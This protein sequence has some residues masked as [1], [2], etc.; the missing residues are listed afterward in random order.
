MISKATNST[1]LQPIDDRFE[2]DRGQTVEGL[3]HSLQ[4]WEAI[5]KTDGET[6]QLCLFKK[7]GSQLDSD[8]RRLLH[9]LVR[10]IRGVLVDRTARDVLVELLDVVED[11]SEIGLRFFGPGMPLNQVPKSVRERSFSRVRTTSGRVVVWRQISR[12]AQAVGSLHSADIVHGNICEAAVFVDGGDSP[13]LQLGGYEGAVHIGSIDDTST[14]LLEP[15]SIVSI[16]KDWHDLAVLAEGLL[17]VEHNKGNTL[18]PN[19]QKLLNRLKN[20]PKFSHIE[21][22]NLASEIGDLCNELQRAGSSGRSELVLFPSKDVIRKDLRVLVPKGVPVPSPNELIEQMADDLKSSPPLMWRPPNSRTILLFTNRATYELK[23]ES[24]DDR[25]ARVVACRPRRANDPTLNAEELVS[26]F[27]LCKNPA[28]AKDRIRRSGGGAQSWSA[29]N[30]EATEAVQEEKLPQW[31]ALNLIEIF[32]LMASRLR[33]YP[34]EILE[35]P[36]GGSVRMAARLDTNRDEWRAKLGR[37][38]AADS[39]NR[40]LAHDDGNTDWTLATTDA[41]SIGAASPS[42]SLAEIADRNG[43]RVFTFDVE[44][45]LP[46]QRNV[47]LRPRPDQGQESV[48]RRRLRSISA[49][50]SDHDLL[51]AL[52]DPNNVTLD[53]ALSSVASPGEPHPDLDSSKI[54]AWNSIQEGNSIDLVVGPPGVGK[55]FLVSRLV[56]SVLQ[57][58]PYSRILISAQNHD[59]LVEMQR[60]LLSHLD[61]EPHLLVRVE[62]PLDGEERTELRRDSISVLTDLL[63]RDTNPLLSEYRRDVEQAVKPRYNPSNSNID[64]LLRDTDHLLLRSADITLATANS[65]IVEELRDDGERF[66]WVIVE[67]AARASGPELLGVLSL[68]NRRLLI[69]DHHQLAP[70]EAERKASFYEAEVAKTLLED[71]VEAIE[72][73]SD[74]PA[75]LPESLKEL[76]DDD[77]LFGDVVAAAARL[78]QPFREIS[79]REEERSFDLMGGHVSILTEQSRMHPVICKIVSDSFY[80][81]RLESSA[82]AINRSPAV[83]TNKEFLSAPLVILDLPSLSVTRRRTFEEKVGT[84]RQNQIEATTLIKVLKELS[85]SQGEVSRTLAVLTPFTAQKSLLERELVQLVDPETGKISGFTSP[86]G[87]GEFVHT[88]DGFQGGEADLVVVS[89]V[90][91]NEWV[92]PRALGFLSDRRRMNVLLS[93]ARDKL[94][95]I[96]S[97]RFL[98]NAV[99]AHDPDGEGGGRLDFLQSILRSIEEFSENG[100]CSIVS[101]DEG[102]MFD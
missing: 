52:D 94:V 10:R 46:I 91:N 73:V 76:A 90:R 89:L 23:P 40:E 56:G 88:V 1:E 85:P 87:N 4:R 11:D 69:G 84:S 47:I 41:L 59:A 21:S 78:E 18:L 72:T 20:P 95:L 79:E 19:E 31:Y 15:G 12:L 57:N 43:R 5:S 71:A 37:P 48:I 61:S 83:A 101:C 38:S 17:G 9:E 93:R 51:L 60:G 96:T 26:E 50:R 7:T 80:G 30:A 34:V 97:L 44:G 67:E 29:L 100:T 62:K 68:G 14:Q 36:A 55:S 64:A 8:L 32:S 99:R 45:K 35:T 70:F 16:R 102:G 92:G 6:Y 13:V 63:Q 28:D 86:K 75:E 2:L 3:A 65:Y 49:V 74:L 81:G 33:H 54:D 22:R 25:L 77:A 98:G 58:A 24:G 82:R 39:L 66:D 42:I 53:D 27:R